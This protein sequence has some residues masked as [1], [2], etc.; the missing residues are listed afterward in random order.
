MSSGLESS[1]YRKDSF[2]IAGNLEGHVHCCPPWRV[3][4]RRDKIV[5]GRNKTVEESE[6]TRR[7]SGAAGKTEGG[8]KDSARRINEWPLRR[9][10][11]EEEN[12]HQRRNGWE[13][14]E[15]ESQFCQEP[16]ARG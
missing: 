14:G 2:E 9:M 5:A 16:P 11:E 12:R 6:K 15:S 4:E 10:V 8:E 7:L 1:K 3:R 13:N